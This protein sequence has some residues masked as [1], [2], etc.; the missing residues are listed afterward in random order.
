MFIRRYFDI[1]I[2]KIGMFK[3]NIS[4]FRNVILILLY[5]FFYKYKIID[6]YD[7]FY[8]KAKY[9]YMLKNYYNKTNK[10]YFPKTIVII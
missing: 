6:N 4:I 9:K 7:I 2:H 10:R 5:K 3:K 8:D 1:Y